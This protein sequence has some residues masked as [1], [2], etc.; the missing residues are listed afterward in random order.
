MQAKPAQII[1]DV[2]SLV[3]NPAGV[4]HYAGNLVRALGRLGQGAADMEFGSVCFD[5]KRRFDRSSVPGGNWKTRT[6]PFPGRVVNKWWGLVPFPSFEAFAGGADLFHFPNFTLPPVRRAKTVVT[7]HDAAFVRLPETIEPRNLAFLRRSMPGS[8]RRADRVIAVSEFTRR[9]LMECL[10]V[11]PEKISVTPEGVDARF[12]DDPGAE[13]VAAFR[14][15]RGLPERFVLAVGTIEPR[16]NLVNLLRAF[17]RL[18]KEGRGDLELVIAGGRGW[19]YDGIFAETARLGLEKCVRFIGYVADAELPL[20]YRACEVFAFVSL[21]EGFGLPPLEAMAS[22]VPVVISEAG[23]LCE[24][25]GRAA[26]SAP[27]REP[28]AIAA[29]VAALIDD[30]KLRNDMINAGLLRAASFTWDKTA[31]ETARAYRKTLGI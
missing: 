27:A 18:R 30:K 1:I 26:M 2:Q 29:C 11:A 31:G 24:V 22:G 3:R 8:L 6:M 28:E 5:F 17:S 21:Y 9:E 23:A 14:K 25:C 7:V 12:F 20:L 19:L 13:R 15:G 4:G 10:D 16:K